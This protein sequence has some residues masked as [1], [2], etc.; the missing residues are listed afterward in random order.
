MCVC[1]CVSLSNFSTH[2]L[3][4]SDLFNAMADQVCMWYA[5]AYN[6]GNIMQVGKLGTKFIKVFPMDETLR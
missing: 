6:V 1:V 2:F 5:Y 3:H 4:C